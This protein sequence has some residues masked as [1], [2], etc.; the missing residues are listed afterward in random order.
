MCECSGAS[1]SVDYQG[2]EAGNKTLMDRRDLL[3]YATFFQNMTQGK[4]VDFNRSNSG[5]PKPFSIESHILNICDMDGRRLV[6]TAFLQGWF[7]GHGWAKT[8]LKHE[9][10]L[11]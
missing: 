2:F 8:V 9:P 6:D 11:N 7:F 3:V 1:F 5:V 10:L 4:N